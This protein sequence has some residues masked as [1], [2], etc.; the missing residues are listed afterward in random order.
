MLIHLAAWLILVIRLPVLVVD[1]RTM[2][3]TAHSCPGGC[4][5]LPI[6]ISR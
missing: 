6:T 5:Y 3:Q 1:E 4:T 2:P